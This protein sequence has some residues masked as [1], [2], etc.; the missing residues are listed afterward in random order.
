VHLLSGLARNG[1]ARQQFNRDSG[2]YEV[3]AL[4]TVNTVMKGLIWSHTAS[5][6]FSFCTRQIR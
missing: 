6:G 3:L 5:I 1:A 4:N 2:L